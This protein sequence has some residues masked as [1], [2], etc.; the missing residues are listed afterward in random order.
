MALRF[1]MEMTLGCRCRRT[2]LCMHALLL[3]MIRQEVSCVFLPAFKPQNAAN[4]AFSVSGA[5]RFL[6]DRVKSWILYLRA[7]F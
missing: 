7:D 6:R 2:D 1:P 3:P 5:V 4:R